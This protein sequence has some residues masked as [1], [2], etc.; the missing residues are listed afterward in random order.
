[1]GCALGGCHNVWSLDDLRA[2][3]DAAFDAPRPDGE[4][5]GCPAT[6]DKILQVTA[7]RYRLEL[8]ADDWVAAANDCANDAPGLTHLMVL[9]NAAE[10]Q[11]LVTLPAT[12]LVE[13]AF[14]GGTD[15]LT[16]T[17]DYRWVTSEVTGYAV[18]I[19]A[20][21]WEENQPDNTGQCMELRVVSGSLHDEGC[22]NASNYIC[23][24]DG[25]PN[26]PTVYQ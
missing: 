23:E 13:D 14:I 21:G 25:R 9:S 19:T 24:C 17:N 6:Y 15:L 11:A 8:K 18:P 16:N 26:D 20:G 12:F 4:P 5:A 3:D 10:Q 2:P 1:M 22:G 7:S